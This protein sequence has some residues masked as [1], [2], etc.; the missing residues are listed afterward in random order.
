MLQFSKEGYTFPLHTEFSQRY[1]PKVC[2]TQTELLGIIHG[3]RCNGSTI[4]RILSIHGFWRK[5]GGCVTCGFVR[6][7]ILQGYDVSGFVILM[8]LVS[9]IKMLLN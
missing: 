5:W 9:L 6:S 8:K 7:E 3:F 2:S 4:D 1:S